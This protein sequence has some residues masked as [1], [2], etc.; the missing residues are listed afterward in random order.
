MLLRPRSSFRA[1]AL[2]FFLAF[3]SEVA[4]LT[5]YLFAIIPFKTIIA[6]KPMSL[7]SSFSFICGLYVSP[8]AISNF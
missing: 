5:L 8:T 7:A 6:A 1:T 4:L 3:G 2:A